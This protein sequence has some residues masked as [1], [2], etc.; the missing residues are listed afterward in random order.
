MISVIVPVYNVEKYL[1]KCIDS[2][3]NQTYKNIEIV[4][5]DDGSTDASGKICDEYQVNHKNIR[6]V[7]KKNDGLGMARNSG[8]E[9]IKGD[10]VTFVDSDDY[11]DSKLLEIM[12]NH[13]QENNLDMCKTGFKKVNDEKKVYKEVRYNNEFFHNDE[14]GKVLLP[15][16]IGSLPDK[17]DSIEMCVCA[18]LYK[19]SIIK[20][21]GILFPSE[22]VLISEDLVFNIEYMQY[23]NNASTIDFVGYN[24]RY[25]PNS[26]SH[27]YKDNRFDMCKFFYENIKERLDKYKYDKNTYYRLDRIFFIYLKMCI[28]QEKKSISNKSKKDS[29][30]VI[31]RICSDKLVLDAINDYPIKKM[32]IKQKTFLLLIKKQKYKKLYFLCNLNII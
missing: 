15:R 13:M 20:K 11:I 30:E 32:G 24:Y 9:I 16:M 6:V 10:Y 2:I 19:T 1:R 5:V 3:L 21:H 17:K 14:V 7:H 22:R 12:Y 18:V 26:L 31:K 23:A 4:L 29:I 28:S 25:N 27:K 8:M